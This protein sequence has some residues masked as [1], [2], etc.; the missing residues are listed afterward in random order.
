MDLG[1]SLS[2]KMTLNGFEIPS[3]EQTNIT[4]SAV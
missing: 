2:P 4:E 3:L 1:Y